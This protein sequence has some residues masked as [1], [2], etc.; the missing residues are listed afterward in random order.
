MTC[1]VQVAG[2]ISSGK[3]GALTQTDRGPTAR[4]LRIGPRLR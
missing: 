1:G 3:S 2:A 4:R